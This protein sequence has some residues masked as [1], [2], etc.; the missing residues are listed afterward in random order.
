M[1]RFIKPL[2]IRQDEPALETL[3]LIE[4]LKRWQ[5]GKPSDISTEVHNAI[6]AMERWLADY[7][8]VKG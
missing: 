3:H 8:R 5:R 4:Q 7:K 2:N 1:R 6:M